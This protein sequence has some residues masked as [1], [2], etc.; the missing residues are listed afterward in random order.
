MMPMLRTL[1]SMV[2]CVFNARCL[3]YGKQ[4]PPPNTQHRTLFTKK[5]KTRPDC[6]SATGD[7]AM[8]AAVVVFLGIRPTK[9]WPGEHLAKAVQRCPVP[10]HRVPCRANE[11]KIIG[12]I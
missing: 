8:T 3:V 5:T 1:S 6:R 7:Q 10:N 2:V 12:E 9:S 4:L 11:S